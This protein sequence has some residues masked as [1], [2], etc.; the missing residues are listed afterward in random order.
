[1]CPTLLAQIGNLTK[2]SRVYDCQIPVSQIN[3]PC[4]TK[5]GNHIACINRG[6]TAE[7]G[8]MTLAQ[9]KR[10]FVAAYQTSFLKPIHDI[11]YQAGNPLLCR[12]PA[13]IDGELVNSHLL[14]GTC[15]ESHFE[16]V[17]T[18]KQEGFDLRAVE[19]SVTNICY[20]L[21]K[22]GA[23]GSNTNVIETM[24][25]GSSRERICRL[26]FGSAIAHAAHPLQIIGMNSISS[27][28]R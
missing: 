26:P 3:Q 18:A 24:S 19:T 17:R 22:N 27:I 13:E 7:I 9:R 14:V 28:S 5:I 21:D 16:Q 25:P 10:K 20:R 1:M 11:E 15:L 2:S 6:E 8:D 4:T 23:A 12:P